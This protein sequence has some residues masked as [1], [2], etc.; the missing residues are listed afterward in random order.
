MSP[1]LEGVAWAAAIVL[2]LGAAYELLVATEVVPIGDVPGEGDPASGVVLAASL[3][4][5][6]VGAGASFVR[7]TRSPRPR[8][9][10]WAL[11]PALGAACMAAHWLSFDAYY[12]P[13]L[14][15]HSEGGIV[16]G[17]W[18]VAV[19]IAAGLVA[20]VAVAA[21]RLGAVLAALLL[22]AEALTVY[23]MPLGK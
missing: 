14:R 16:A 13:T 20:A 6:L 22:L 23:A 3:L 5:Y 10:V 21:P 15:R 17:P 19:L 8:L 9:V 1:R 2:G 7:A 11:L 4:A 12:A 18:V